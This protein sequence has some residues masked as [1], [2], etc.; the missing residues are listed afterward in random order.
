MTKAEMVKTVAEETGITPAQADKA[1]SATCNAI[2]AGAL[3]GEKSHGAGLR[4]V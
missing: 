4:Y 1:I 2:L 3:A